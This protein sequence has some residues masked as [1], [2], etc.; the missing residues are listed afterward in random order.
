M[1]LVCGKISPRLKQGLSVLAIR[2]SS[3]KTRKRDEHRC[4]GETSFFRKISKAAAGRAATLTIVWQRLRFLCVPPFFPA[5]LFPLPFPSQLTGS[6]FRKK[7]NISKALFYSSCSHGFLFL[8]RINLLFFFLLPQTKR[9]KRK[10]KHSKWAC[11]QHLKVKP[12]VT[13]GEGKLAE[14]T[15]NSLL[16]TVHKKQRHDEGGG[17]RRGE[18]WLCYRDVNTHTT[19]TVVVTWHRDKTIALLS[20]LG[21]RRA[22]ADVS[23]FEL[24]DTTFGRLSKAV[25]SR[26]TGKVGR[27]QKASGAGMRPDYWSG[28]LCVL[29]RPSAKQEIY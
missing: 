21:D 27:Y 9:K 18:P 28:A 11:N 23:R 12:H 2:S 5:P 26:S 19:P 29:G 20:H 3:E 7:K 8:P 25:R 24:E 10:E 4:A 22:S 15:W 14:E 16:A 6:L 17:R 13:G 1:L